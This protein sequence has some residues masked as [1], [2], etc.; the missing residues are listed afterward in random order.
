M[1]KIILFLK[2]LLILF[3]YFLVRT[4][5]FY[6][7]DIHKEL[8]KSEFLT[9]PALLFLKTL[10]PLSLSYYIHTISAKQQHLQ[11]QLL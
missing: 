6:F 3:V 2:I 11:P 5:T 8:T 10:F 4:L 1:N 7:Y 9:P